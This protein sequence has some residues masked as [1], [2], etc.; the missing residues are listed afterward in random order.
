MVARNG[1]CIISYKPLYGSVA[2]QFY[3]S[4]V[5][6]PYFEYQKTSKSV[7]RVEGH[8]VVNG[9]CVFLLHTVVKFSEYASFSKKHLGQ[10]WVAKGLICPPQDKE[11]WLQLWQGLRNSDSICSVFS[12]L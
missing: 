8:V 5:I 12:G 10:R 6:V 2:F 1:N 9:I 3:S 7:L 4:L 11:L